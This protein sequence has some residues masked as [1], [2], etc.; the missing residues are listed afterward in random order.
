MKIFIC[1]VCGH[2]EFNSAPE[3]CPVCFAKKFTQNDSVFEESME[4]SSEGAVKHIPDVKI[5]KECGL[6]PESACTDI[7]VRIGETLHP[8]M[9]NHFIQWI[10]CYLDEKYVSRIMLT[11]D[12]NPSVVFHL[13]TEGSKV[14]IVENCNIHGYW[15]TDT[16]L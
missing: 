8:M 5:N 15:K 3:N 13:K 10:D 12:M 11:P 7:L 9:E 16:N 1:Q 14:T 4:K 6:I 2:I